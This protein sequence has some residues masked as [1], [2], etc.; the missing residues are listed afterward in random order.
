MFRVALRC[1]L[2]AFLKRLV[3]HI[4]TCCFPPPFLRMDGR[5]MFNI[6]SVVIPWNV[7]LACFTQRMLH[8]SRTVNHDI[9]SLKLDGWSHGC[10]RKI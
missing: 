9:S 3:G 1:T 7:S 6:Q 4:N 2:I 8:S 5:H 10:S